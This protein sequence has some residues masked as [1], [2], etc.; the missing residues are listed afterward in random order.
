MGR[1][2]GPGPSSRRARPG[3]QPVGEAAGSGTSGGA[4]RYR[5]HAFQASQAMSSAAPTRRSDTAIMA[6]A[7]MTLISAD[8]SRRMIVAYRLYA[9][10]RLAATVVTYMKSIGM[11]AYAGL[12]RVDASHRVTSSRLRAASSWFEAPN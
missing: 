3:R 6:H 1:G 12:R 7:P 5:F 4:S 8:P 2:L 10:T 9:V 11:P